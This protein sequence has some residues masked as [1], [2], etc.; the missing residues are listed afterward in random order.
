MSKVA[1][2]SISNDSDKPLLISLEP[3]GEDYT[4]LAKE[5]VEIIA[6]DCGDDFYYSVVYY[7]DFVAVYAEGGRR[8]EYL[9]VYIKGIELQ[10][11][12]NREFSPS[13]FQKDDVLEAGELE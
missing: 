11:G 12:Y 3:W 13:G 7:D 1:K 5:E 10:C 2:I 4:L 6:Q 8:N 9:R